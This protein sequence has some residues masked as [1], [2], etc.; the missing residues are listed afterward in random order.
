MTTAIGAH[1]AIEKDANDANDLLLAVTAINAF[2]PVRGTVRVGKAGW[3]L[4]EKEIVGASMTV[5]LVSLMV[6]I[7]VAVGTALTMS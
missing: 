1:E 5:I 3:R 2:A 7:S 4:T 6:V